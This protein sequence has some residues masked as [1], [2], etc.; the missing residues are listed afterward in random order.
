MTPAHPG[1][2]PGD[3][4]VIEA[5]AEL[6]PAAVLRIARAGAV[7]VLSTELTDRVAARR[8][9]V[10]AALASD[11]PVYGVNTAMGAL[12]EHRLSEAEQTRHQEALMLARSAGGPPWLAEDET[13]AVLAV[14]LRTFLNNDSGVSAGLC[15]RLADMLACQI[16]PAVP[17]GGLGSAGEILALAHLAAPISGGGM[18]L[19]DAG[20]GQDAVPAAP[21]LEAVGLAPLRLGPKE[22]VAL[23]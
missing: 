19:P 23:I 14:R 3:P 21:A 11:E 9:R 20:A 18:V 15:R 12:S 1:Q 6:G 2:R 17:R 5:A 8:A 13:R 10:L 16:L 22:G 7:P 4:I